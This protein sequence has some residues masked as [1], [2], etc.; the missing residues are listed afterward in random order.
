VLRG[1]YQTLPIAIYGWQVSLDN[2]RM[3]IAADTDTNIQELLS[4]TGLALASEDESTLPAIPIGVE[5]RLPLKEL[6]S[7]AVSALKIALPYWRDVRGNQA[8]IQ[9]VTGPDHP[10]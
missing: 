1:Q 6:P 3:G 5:G 10:P 2:A 4:H 9:K 7:D 8:R